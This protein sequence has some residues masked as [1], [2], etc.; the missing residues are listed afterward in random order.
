[1]KHK[2]DVIQHIKDEDS[3]SY[4]DDSL[5]RISSW[6]A[7][8][9]FREL[10]QRYEDNELVKP[11]LQRHYVW[12]RVEAS[13]FIDSVLLD[14]PIPSIFLAQTPDEKLLIVDGFQR[15]MTVRDFV[16]GIF[17]G[18][19]KVFRLSRSERINERW[20][21]RAFAE[22]GDAEQRRVRNTTIHAIIFVQQQ[23]QDDDTSLFQVFERINTSGRTLLPQEI[24]NCVAQGKMNS[25]LFDLNKNDKWRALFGLVEPDSRMRDME[26]ILRFFALS[27]EIFRNDQRERLSLKRF[28]DLFMKNNKNPD[29]PVVESLRRRFLS[30]VDLVFG[31][32]GAVAFHNVSPSDPN[33]L[34]A[35]FSP[36]LCD[37][38]LIA[39]DCALTADNYNLPPEPENARRALLGD[40]DF[41]SAISKETMSR[42]CIT[43]RIGMACDKLFE[44]QYEQR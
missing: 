21:G 1:M 18:D 25:L 29:D 24:R 30:S 4:S 15:I 26:F 12:D 33:K 43:T 35:K 32:F 40:D 8:L 36:T 6:G 5:F 38:I 27:S 44:V 22:L 16:R 39:A 41:R 23:P 3:D 17:S 20:R 9:S 11:E 37:S 14:L 31:T 28:L 7:D 19:G 10:I 34:V 2:R 42:K 13:R